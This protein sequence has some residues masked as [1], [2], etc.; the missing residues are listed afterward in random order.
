MGND[1]FSSQYQQEPTASSGGYFEPEFFTKIFTH[2]LSELNTY[3]FVDNAMSL[4]KNADNRAVVVMGAGY[5][6]S[7]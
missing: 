7:K 4:S 6:F 3:I 1:E 5:F 2:E